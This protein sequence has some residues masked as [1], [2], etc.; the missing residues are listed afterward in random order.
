M[1][2]GA[3]NRSGWTN[4]NSFIRDAAAPRPTL[5]GISTTINSISVTATANESGGSRSKK[6]SIPIQNKLKW[7]LDKPRQRDHIRGCK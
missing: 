5:S 3:G 4:A 1:Q 2:D 6:L 7:S